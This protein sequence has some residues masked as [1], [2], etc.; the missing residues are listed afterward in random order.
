MLSDRYKFKFRNIVLVGIP[1]CITQKTGFLTI[2]KKTQENNIL[3]RTNFDISYFISKQL[4]YIIR[5]LCVVG[6]RKF[7]IIRR[8]INFIIR[9]FTLFSLM[10]TVASQH[11]VHWL[12]HRHSRN[13]KLWH[14]FLFFSICFERKICVDIPIGILF[15]SF[16]LIIKF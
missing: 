6:N 10:E 11:E 5:C 4:Y 1:Y 15:P 8:W 14:N 13:K 2:S 12:W 7:L 9:I 16:F 3:S